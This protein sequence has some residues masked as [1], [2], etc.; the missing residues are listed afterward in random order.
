MNQQ[1]QVFTDSTEAVLGIDAGGRIFFSNDGCSQLLGQS[2]Q[3]LHGGRCAEI[4][5]GLDLD[6]EPVCSGSCP[7]RQMAAGTLPARDFDMLIGADE[8]HPVLVNVGACFTRGEPDDWA[9]GNV[10]LLLRPVN[11][12]R[13]LQRIN[14]KQA[15]RAH[16]P[17]SGSRR[18]RAGHLTKRER[19][20]LGL[21]SNG[22]KTLQI[23]ERL[24]IST[25]TVR[26][27]CKNIHA[28]LDV[29]SRTEAVSIALRQGLI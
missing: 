5:C 14:R 3:E 4:L 9:G 17:A 2:P 21:V 10:F 13:L 1:Q 15:V 27:H 11:T 19:E 29:H 16:G 8:E 22:L 23:A 18:R 6:G 20:L 26:N 28:K 24:N 12:Q 25:E 7:V